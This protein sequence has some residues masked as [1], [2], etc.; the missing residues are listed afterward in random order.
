MYLKKLES[1]TYKKKKKK[2]KRSSMPNLK[3]G[4]GFGER[5][6]ARERINDKYME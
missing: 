4:K 2:L 5:Q 3:A 6:R 1:R